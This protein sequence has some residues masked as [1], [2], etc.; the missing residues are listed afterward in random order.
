VH[1]HR[2]SGFARSVSLWHAGFVSGF[3]SF[4]LRQHAFAVAIPKAYENN[5]K[6]N[7]ATADSK[8]GFK[9]IVHKYKSPCIDFVLYGVLFFCCVG[10]R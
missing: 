2:F 4:P 1:P 7:E 3:P 9:I 6:E 10:R 5:V 8:K